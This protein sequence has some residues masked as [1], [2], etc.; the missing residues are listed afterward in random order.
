MARKVSKKSVKQTKKQVYSLPKSTSNYL[1]RIETDIKSNQSRLS[2]I[3]G[4]LIVLVI[5]ILIF[6]YFNKS[7]PDLGPAQQTEQEQAQGDVSVDNLPGKYTIKE[8]DTL[9]LIAEKYYSDGNKFEDLARANNLVDVNTIVVGQVIEIPKLSE[10]EAM[11]TTAP[12]STP[13]ESAVPSA[14]P[15]PSPEATQTTEQSSDK[16]TGGSDNTI[17]GPSIEGN[18]Y[19]VVEGDWLST[20]AARS[21]GDVFAFKKIADANNIQN[22]DYIVPGQVLKIP[23]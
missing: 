23:R 22:P 5:G 13:A 17:W 9:F 6:N 12:E 15:S 18:T 11:A 20:I 7:T 8:G 19:T 14:M 3:L 4:G 1:N 16:G 21:Y 2:M 10:P